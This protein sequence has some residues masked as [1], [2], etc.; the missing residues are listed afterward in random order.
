MPQ[1]EASLKERQA[2]RRKMLDL[3]IAE[4]QTA[5]L[6]ADKTNELRERA[7]ER[8]RELELKRLEFCLTAKECIMTCVYYSFIGKLKRGLKE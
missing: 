2:A 6:P 8:R 3:L 5:G 7:E 4:S 1:N